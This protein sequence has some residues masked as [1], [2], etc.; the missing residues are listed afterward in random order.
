MNAAPRLLARSEDASG[1][2]QSAGVYD[3]QRAAV[4]GT[5]PTHVAHVPTRGAVRRLTGPTQTPQRR[6][7]QVRGASEVRTAA[8]AKGRKQH[9]FGNRR[10][11]RVAFVC[12]SSVSAPRRLRA[13][14][15]VPLRR[16]AHRRAAMQRA[17]RLAVHRQSAARVPSVKPEAA[18][19]M[20]QPRNRRRRVPSAARTRCRRRAAR[21]ARV[22]HQDVAGTCQDGF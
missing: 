3:A 16:T 10:R 15:I 12:A 14:C 17:A 21:A 11:M 19:C 7:D 9:S 8:R 2:E 1:A 5:V 18:V 6:S 13:R 22:T 20:Q 4:H